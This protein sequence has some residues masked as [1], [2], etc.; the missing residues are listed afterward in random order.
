[1]SYDT[2]AMSLGCDYNTKAVEMTC[3]ASLSGG[4]DDTETPQT[5]VLSGSEVSFIP[6]TVVEGASLLSGGAS[7]SASASATPASQSTSLRTTVTP[8]ASGTAAAGSQASGSG[9][10]P[11]AS[12]S[13]PAA[14]TGAAARFG[15]EGSALLALAG[16]AALHAW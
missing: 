12:G 15:I 3:T 9:A 8:S 14:S 6:A 13:S 11:T 1:M 16:A 2:V 5:A 7:A 10:T 4:N